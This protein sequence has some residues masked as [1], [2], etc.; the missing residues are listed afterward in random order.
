MFVGSSS[1]LIVS[2]IV[3]GDWGGF[4]A[5]IVDFLI[6]GVPFLSQGSL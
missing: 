5:S 4:V 3:D 6:S 1:S 2:K